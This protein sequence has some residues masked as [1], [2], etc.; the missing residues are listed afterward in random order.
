MVGWSYCSVPEVKK[1]F[2]VEKAAHFMVYVG[3][4]GGEGRGSLGLDS[5]LKGMLQ[6]IQVLSTRSHLVRFPPLEP[7]LQTSSST[8]YPSGYIQGLKHSVS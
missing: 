6:T 2:M 8:H 4:G 7:S 5:L 3:V 1:K